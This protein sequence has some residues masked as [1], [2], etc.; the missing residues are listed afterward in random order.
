MPSTNLEITKA[1]IDDFKEIQEYMLLAKEENAEKTYAKLK[2][3]Y[4]SLKAILNVAGVNLTDIDE[5]KE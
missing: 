3:K 4:L 1:A 2:K 5:M